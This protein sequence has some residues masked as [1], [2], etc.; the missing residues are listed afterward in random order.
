M[1]E[2]LDYAEMLEIPVSTVNVVKKKSIFKKPFFAPKQEEAP[3]VASD[4]LKELV[5]D[6]VNERVGAF[7]YAED[8]T[9]PEKPAKK[10]FF[11]ADKGSKIILTELIAVC[12]LAVAIFLTNIFM[13]TSA[14]NTF[15]GTLTNPKGKEVEPT[16]KE[17]TL[18]PV[19][20]ETSD[21]EVLV[22]E[23]GVLSFTAKGSVYPVCAGK[24]ASVTKTDGTYTVEIAHTST[25]SSVITGLTEVYSAVGT[26]VKANI[27]F[28]YSDGEGEVRVSM[29]DDGNLLN[30]FS[31]SGEVPVW[32]S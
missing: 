20:S 6:S 23:S 8:L 17:I 14:I 29:Y 19:I 5:V 28:A 15:I 16:Y 2:E 3:A 25:F 26:A 10:K 32:N 11:G 7:T 24:V 31:M 1:N 18:S 27:P 12:V 22:S 21:A 4:E 9:E 13:P 30:C